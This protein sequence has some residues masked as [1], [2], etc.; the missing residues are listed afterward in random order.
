[1]QNYS[2]D[3]I[4]LGPPA[5]TGCPSGGPTSSSA[6]IVDY[7]LASASTTAKAK[8]GYFFGAASTAGTLQYLITATPASQGSSGVKGFCAIE[9]NVVRFINPSSGSAVADRTAC[10]AL[11]AIGN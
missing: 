4:S 5:A 6:C 9:D 10:L 7:Q 8:S 11:T 2:P 3:L 1:Y